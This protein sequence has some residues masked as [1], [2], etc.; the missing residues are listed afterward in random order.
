MPETFNQL[1][2]VRPPFLLQK[3]L[4]RN[5]IMWNGIEASKAWVERQIPEII[6]FSFENSMHEVEK[7][8]HQQISGERCDFATI[9]LCHAYIS[10]G[11]YLSIA[12]KYAGTCDP[13]AFELINSY[14]KTLRKAKT[15]TQ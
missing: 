3:T 13:V 9:A 8:Y 6:K 5:L 2:Y 14:I 4:S 7:R 15:A 11:A 1:E 10:T 12:Y